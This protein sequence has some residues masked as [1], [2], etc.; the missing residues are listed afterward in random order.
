MAGDDILIIETDPIATIDVMG[1]TDGILQ[2]MPIIQCAAIIDTMDEGK[3]ILIMS[4]Y[5]PQSN[6]KTIHS[7]NQL[8]HFSCKVLVTAQCHGVHQVLYT[9]KSYAVPLNVHNGLFYIDM[10]IPNE[11]NLTHYPHSFI[12]SDSEWDPVIIDNE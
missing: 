3:I 5:A 1:V 4:Q 2:S 6:D 7:K 12:T 9:L 10:S 8:E 11:D